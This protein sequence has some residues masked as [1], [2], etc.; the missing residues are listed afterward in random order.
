MLAKRLDERQ[1]RLANRLEASPSTLSLRPSLLPA[2]N[3]VEYTLIT[4]IPTAEIAD[5]ALPRA[6]SRSRGSSHCKAKEVEL[7]K[8]STP[9]HLKMFV[10][11]CTL[12]GDSKGNRT[13]LK[14][15]WEGR[16]SMGRAWHVMSIRMMDNS[17]MNKETAT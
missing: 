12:S 11:D 3:T 13:M 5:L 6:G 16:N 8:F 15:T 14:E 9:Q 4:I 2:Q 10:I 1:R 17:E 7:E